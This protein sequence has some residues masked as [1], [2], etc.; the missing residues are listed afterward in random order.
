MTGRVCS[1]ITWPW[2]L[3]RNSETAIRTISQGRCPEG[4]SLDHIALKFPSTR[5]TPVLLS[6]SVHIL[7]L[8]T[9]V[10]V[11]IHSGPALQFSSLVLAVSSSTSKVDS[12]FIPL[13]AIERFIFTCVK[14]VEGC[15]SQYFSKSFRGEN[16]PIEKPRPS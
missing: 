14:L 12:T 9:Q 1:N 15:S 10:Y 6:E 3:Y 2:P 7:Y 5:L 13:H 16:L 11:G 4:E 8:H